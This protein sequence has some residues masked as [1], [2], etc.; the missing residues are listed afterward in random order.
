MSGSSEV[1]EDAAAP[2]ARS[3]AGDDK[4][5]VIAIDDRH[6]AIEVEL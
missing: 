2:F 6:D 5:D 1:D 4:G 3:K